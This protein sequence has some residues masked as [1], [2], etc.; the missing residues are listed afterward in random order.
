[1]REKEHETI[2][3]HHGK[4]KCY[5]SERHKHLWQQGHENNSAWWI[6]K[7]FR[8]LDV[9]SEGIKKFVICRRS[10]DRTFRRNQRKIRAERPK[11]RKG[12]EICVTTGEV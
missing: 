7:D 5:Q 1:M 8:V 4:G 3:T 9:S 6:V 10:W 12:E 11:N 2:S